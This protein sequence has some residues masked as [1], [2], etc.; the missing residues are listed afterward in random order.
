MTIQTEI[1]EDRQ[2]PKQLR[3]WA[4]QHGLYLNRFRKSSWRGYPMFRTRKARFTEGTRDGKRYIRVLPHLD[5]M[6]I[7]D[8]YFDRWANSL[9]A[10]VQMP[11]TQAEFDAAVTELLKKSRARVAETW[12]D[13]CDTCGIDLKVGQCHDCTFDGLV[14]HG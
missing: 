6:D 5:R 1:D 10:S 14:D 4:E 9:G 8:G 7:C 3:H 2:A 12:P 13:K 11:K